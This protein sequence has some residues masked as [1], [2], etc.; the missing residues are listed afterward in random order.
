M[1]LGAGNFTGLPHHAFSGHHS[2]ASHSGHQSSFAASTE[3]ALQSAFNAAGQHGGWGSYGGGGYSGSGVGVTGN[4]VGSSIDNFPSYH[5]SN[6]FLE[7]RTRQFAAAAVS[8][9]A[10][11]MGGVCSGYGVDPLREYHQAQAHLA[12]SAAAAVS[13]GVSGG[14]YPSPSDNFSSTL[15]WTSQVSM[16][17]KRK[18]YTKYQ[19]LEL[20]KEY[21]YSTYITKQK[22]W[23]LARNLQLTERQVK[24]W[25]QNRRMK[26]KKHTQRAQ[27]NHKSSTNAS[28]YKTSSS[29]GHKQEHT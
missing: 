9:Q 3:A 2:L 24:I 6:S 11:G 23:E 5:L 21:L 4:S 17:K 1:T 18:P 12:A 14:F 26:T 13:A 8:Q 25:F 22:R 10:A 19:N 20:E 29:N 27:S 16:R 28:G 15:D 7:E